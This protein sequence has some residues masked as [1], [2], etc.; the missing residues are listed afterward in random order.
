M[1]PAPTQSADA[2]QKSILAR[3][4]PG[5]EA[6]RR[7]GWQAATSQRFPELI[8]E[9]RS[10][11]DVVDAVR[12]ARTR[13]MTLAV[14]GSGH[15]YTSTFLRDGGMLLDVSRLRELRWGSR[16]Q[17]VWAQPGITS[18]E[19]CLSLLAQ[20]RAFPT[21]HNGQVGLGG[22]LLGGGMGW[23]G[24][25]WGQLACFNVKA[26]DVVTGRRMRAQVSAQVHP[27]LFWAARGAGPL[28]CA[29]AT[30][31]H[32]GTYP[33]PRVLTSRYVYPL[34]A[35]GEIARWLQP[36]S[37]RKIPDLELFVM[38]RSED[39]G[40]GAGARRQTCLVCA[41]Q[42][43]LEHDTARSALQLVA[44]GAPGGALQHT[45]LAPV[46]FADL[47]D[48][49]R[50]GPERR[51]SADTAWGH[52]AA[53][54]TEIAARC[55]TR[56]PSPATVVII[57]YRGAPQLPEDAACSM[58][59]SVFLQMLGQWDEA[60]GD[61]EN[62]AW[63]EQML[64]ELEPCSHGAYVNESDIIRR[65]DRLRRCFSAAAFE[66]LSRV[67]ATYDPTGLLPPPIPV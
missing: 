22:Y 41:L 52:D 21:G 54:M 17:D 61:H 3:G 30:G 18:R 47:Y 57:N 49:S 24:E 50:T 28:F 29:V 67:R 64:R 51:T 56:V 59:G 7:K 63:I 32:L 10:V 16:T 42:L 53:A 39:A 37:A 27:E 26:V 14:R 8:V 58:A 62:H 40:D 5:Y 25:T 2:F 11:A 46:T 1:T 34:S 31:F 6:A 36:I 13:G 35:A 20:G 33:A 44:R 45:E 12:L 43:A 15:H 65:P 66:R 38:L 9:A 23:N 19:L 4:A 60:V 55:F 48:E